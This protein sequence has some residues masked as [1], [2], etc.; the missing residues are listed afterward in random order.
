MLEFV[1][2]VAAA[3]A[4]VAPVVKNLG[5]I[6]KGGRQ[7]LDFADNILARFARK[8]DNFKQQEELRV[9]LAQVAAMPQVEFDKKAA[10]IIDVEL[11][12]KPPE[13]RK[14]VTEYVK[15]IP[16][17][18][19]ASFSRPEDPTGTT[20]PARWSATRGED[21]LPFLPPRP[22]MF[23]EGDSPPHA[24]RWILSERIGIG[25]F[26]EV[27]KARGRT[28]Q[29]TDSAFKFCLDPVSQQ[30]IL[31]NELENIELVQNELTDHP[32][33]VKLLDAYLEGDTPWLRYQ[34]IPGGD[35]GQLVATWP[36]ELAVRA[37]LAVQNIGILAET[38]AHCHN[39]LSRKVIHRDMKPANVLVG[40]NGTLK[41]TDFGIS[42]TQARQALEE[43]R[44]AAA[45]GASLTSGGS[46]TTPS[47]IRWAS[48]PLYASPQ[49]RLGEDPH[50]SDDVHALGVMLYQML[51]GNLNLQ[52]GVDMWQDLEEQYICQELLDVLSR[53]VASRVER[54][55]QN[56]SELAEALA[57]L[58]K[59]LIVEP[60][61]VSVADRELQLYEE[62]DRRVDDAR[63]KNETARQQLDRREWKA[64]VA[65]LETIFHPVMRD[66]D[67][68][69][70]AVQHRDGKR[71]L[72]GL[73][74]EFALV[75]AGT[76][77]M[78]GQDGKCGDRKVTI[79]R[80][81]YIGVYPVTQEEWQKVMGTNPSRFRKGGRGADKL[82]GVTDSDLKRFP[83]EM[84]SW[85][86]CQVFI[87]KLHESLKE[88]AW[89]Y[90]LPREAEWEYACR[91][92]ATTT[93]LCGWNFYLRSPTNTLSAQ[94]ANFRDSALGRTC[95][96]GL[97]EANT[98]GLFDM[99]GNVDEWCEDALDSHRLV[100]GGG[101]NDVAGSCRAASRSNQPPTGA[102]SGMGLRLARV[103]SGKY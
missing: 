41:I 89:M 77:W 87:K 67:L 48:T 72:N 100:R 29:N 44:M 30:R 63:A 86:D 99:H 75:P 31:E 2:A 102:G 57:R 24:D 21:I 40:K 85:N 84:V 52:L 82:S 4:M 23:R 12:D 73:G 70:R 3:I 56:A 49:Q 19:R 54:R 81:F 91:G 13:Y 5:E 96:V 15:L 36:N 33:I 46:L 76:F 98:L 88:T 17:R 42:D 95:K 78:G 22:P 90:R 1:A 59:R 64:A 51:L 45:T 103:P 6:A 68:Y 26:G 25:G 80:D 28:M 101:W 38:L 58:P 79:D 65:T 55:Y 69:T 92:A 50:T 71:F 14:A 18:V 39:E 94:Q 93:A 37:T 16:P 97:Y 83:V 61:V 27:W 32:N 60:V 7:M 62:I 9:A 10:E 74:M 47:V 20:A 53:S 43:A 34:Y 11:A 35:L 66:E 8:G